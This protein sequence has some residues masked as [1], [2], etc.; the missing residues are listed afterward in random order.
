ME[1]IKSTVK[2]LAGMI[3]PQ[4]NEAFGLVQNLSKIKIFLSQ[5][6]S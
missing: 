6:E 1:L 5:M 4:G 2:Y 3:N